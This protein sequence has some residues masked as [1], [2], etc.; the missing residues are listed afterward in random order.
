MGRGVLI[1]CTLSGGFGGLG[2]LGLRIFFI[3]GF[4]LLA[5]D[6]VLSEMW[7]MWDRTLRNGRAIP[8]G[9]AYAYAAS[10][11]ITAAPG[12]ERCGGNFSPSASGMLRAAELALHDVLFVW[13]MLR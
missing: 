6:C 5:V 9:S 10:C 4:S 8:I 12:H 11:Q 7:Y 2:G 13:P 1:F 3:C